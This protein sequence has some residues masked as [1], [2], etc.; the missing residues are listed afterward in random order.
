M[1]SII[2][3]DSKL[4]IEKVLKTDRLFEMLKWNIP[5]SELQNLIKTL[6][7]NSNLSREANG[8]F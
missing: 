8:N 3:E 6:L 7:T 1:R 2:I 5:L 4:V